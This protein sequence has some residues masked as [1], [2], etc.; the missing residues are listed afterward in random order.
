M[1][2]SLLFIVNLL[3]KLLGLLF[4]FFDFFAH[5]LFCCFLMKY[6]DV[7]D[8]F[9]RQCGIVGARCLKLKRCPLRGDVIVYKFVYNKIVYKLNA[10][11]RVTVLK[12]AYAH[13]KTPLLQ[14][15]VKVEYN[16]T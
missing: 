12:R 16:K 9:M 10:K 15:S 13:I 11:K 8:F 14:H 3:N 4:L 7:N 5:F 2:I 6:Q 1:D